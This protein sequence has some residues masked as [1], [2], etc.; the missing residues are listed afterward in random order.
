MRFLT[1]YTPAQPPS[2]PPS[3]EHMQQMGAL[4]ERMMKTGALVMTGGVL[5]SATGAKVK[6]ARGAYDI[7]LGPFSGGSVL[8]GAAGWAILD[9][10]TREAVIEMVKEF[11][12]VAGDGTSELIQLM[13]GPP[14]S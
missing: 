6:L 7:A 8:M 2:G 10:P 4:M 9:A 3:A 1:L 5:S 13:E 14:P 12:A 11:L